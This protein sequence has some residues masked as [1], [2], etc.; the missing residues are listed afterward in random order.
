MHLAVVFLLVWKFRICH[1]GWENNNI[2]GEYAFSECEHIVS[3]IM[4]VNAKRIEEFAMSLYG[5]LR[6]FSTIQNIAI[7]SWC[8]I[9]SQTDWTKGIL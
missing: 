6:F 9:K 3:A 5:D 2:N 1:Y 4:S 8:L 7:L